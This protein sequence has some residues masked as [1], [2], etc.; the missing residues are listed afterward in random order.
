MAGKIIFP[1]VDNLKR[2][3]VC[4]ENKP[5]AEYNIK[6]K[7]GKLK[8]S[9]RDCRRAR[10]RAWYE[11]NIESERQRAR[12]RIKVYGAKD[13]ERN[14]LW[15][16]ANPEKARHNSRKKL[17]GKKYNMTIEEHDALFV[18]QGSVCGACGSP[19][20]GSKKG[21]STD[22]CH[23]TGVVRGIVC[24]HCNI[25]IGHAKDNIETIRSWI[26]YLERSLG[27]G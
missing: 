1:V 8:S 23:K 22:H 5:A 15:A 13:K 11:Q 20:P 25:G 21:W 6:S 19:E 14:R 7:P 4:R 18:S 10:C 3:T 26:A 9:C 17:L 27:R 24:H 16:A 12:D 2:C